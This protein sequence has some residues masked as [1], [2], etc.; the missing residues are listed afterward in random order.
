M[1]VAMID[2]F[3]RALSGPAAAPYSDTPDCLAGF[4][5]LEWKGVAREGRD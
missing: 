1:R 3:G 4:I 2:V 5:G